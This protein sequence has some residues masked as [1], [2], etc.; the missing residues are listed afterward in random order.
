MNKL[1]NSS[2]KYYGGELSHYFGGAGNIHQSNTKK[3]TL[4]PTPQ[5]EHT[6]GTK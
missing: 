1:K 2:V 5:P 4:T 6:P 3:P